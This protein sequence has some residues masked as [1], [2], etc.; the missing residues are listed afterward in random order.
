MYAIN[1]TKKKFEKIKLN[2]GE[3]NRN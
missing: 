3:E 2:W 1:P